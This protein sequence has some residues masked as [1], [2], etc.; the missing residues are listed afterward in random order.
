M[1]LL[2]SKGGFIVGLEPLS[3]SVRM[4][5]PGVE[6][7]M[8]RIKIM[9]NRINIMRCDNKSN[10]T[11]GYNIIDCATPVPAEVLSE[12]DEKDGVIRTRII[13]LKK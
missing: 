2:D 11:V 6:T 7:A 4:V 13:R 1:L 3:V 9:G 8:Y 10:G 12:M 5:Q